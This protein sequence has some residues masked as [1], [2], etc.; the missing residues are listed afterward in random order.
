[1]ARLMLASD[2]AIGAAGGTSLERCCMGLPS[3]QVVVADNQR[4]SAAALQSFGAALTAEGED[5]AL[6]IKR[7]LDGVISRPQLMRSLS[8]NAA[9]LVDGAGSTRVL[10]WLDGAL[11]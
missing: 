10:N 3:V 1:M 8:E 11:R 5:L 9:R 7:L 6:E 4:D 2:L